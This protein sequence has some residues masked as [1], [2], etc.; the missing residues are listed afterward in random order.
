M[1]LA[2]MLW[3]GVEAFSAA[4]PGS[5]W[6]RLLFAVAVTAPLIVRRSAP[7][8][9]VAAL[10]G[11]LLVRVLLLRG[12]EESTFPFPSLLV[13]TFSVALYARRRW[14]AVAAGTATVAAMLAT[15][16][17]GYYGGPVSIGQVCILGFFVAGAWSAGWLVRWRLAQLTA[18]RSDS[19][20]QAGR[21]AERAAKQ[22]RDR[23]ARE[24]HDVV[25]HSLSII[26]VQAGAAEALIDVSPD[27]AREHIGAA[28]RTAREALGEMRHV[29]EV[30]RDGEST[31]GRLLPQ[32]TLE[33]V[34]DLVEEVRAAGLPVTLTVEGERGAIPAGLDL[35]AFR[36][37]QEALTNARRHAGGAPTSVR[38]G[39]DDTGIDLEV[40]NQVSNQVPG[41]TAAGPP[42]GG[43]GLVGMRER[44]RVYGGS[45]T[46][47]VTGEAFTVT[48]RLPRSAP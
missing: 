36:I 10:I 18:A 21:A 13:G 43:S 29:L 6:Q 12:L 16:P 17:L 14:H 23:I 24:I 11:V 2:L 48:V 20:R 30:T 15:F 37:V 22:E 40:S 1:T 3:A 31:D 34:P 47:G 42:A 8:A 44:A 25:A 19:A 35:A 45:V 38:I 9:V 27:A 46:T 41:T 4:G 5:G 28:R 33:R 26:A 7:V 39:Y 32:P